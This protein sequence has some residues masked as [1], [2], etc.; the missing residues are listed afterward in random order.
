MPKNLHTYIKDYNREKFL[1]AISI[2]ISINALLSGNFV[3]SP[4]VI[5]Y[6]LYMNLVAK[7]EKINCRNSAEYQTLNMCYE[8]VKH[9]IVKNIKEFGFNDVEGLFAYFTHLRVN[10]YLAHQTDLPYYYLESIFG[11]EQIIKALILNN[12]GVCRNYCPAFA[13]IC[14]SFNIDC[15]SV[16][17]DHFKTS[18]ELVIRAED[19]L[20]EEDYKKL[21]VMHDLNA[22]T[23]MD[24]FIK[25]HAEVLEE[26]FG[27]ITKE[28]DD[29]GYFDVNHK[30][31]HC[32][33]VAT[34]ENNS[35]LLDP[36]LNQFYIDK[37]EEGNYLSNQG[38]Y[39]RVISKRFINKYPH[40][41]SKK[42]EIP[43]PLKTPEEMVEKLNE[44][45]ETIKDNIDLMHKMY[46]EIQPVLED[47]DEVYKYILQAH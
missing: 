21:E 38:N 6:A 4:I 12:H 23:D 7:N 3:G 35:Y 39:F 32:I 36:S 37:N 30:Q 14:A 44:R 41:M 26:V 45:T 16:I 13:D 47:A 33:N 22:E 28:L 20:T 11:E 8:K 5:L 2:G 1:S 46:K 9:E 18:Q 15:K 24:A 40:Y 17:V 19:F 25:K 31:K 43:K 27:R 29:L 42:L 34:D 10:N